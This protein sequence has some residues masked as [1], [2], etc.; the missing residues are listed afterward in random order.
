M[1]ELTV[2]KL[3]DAHDAHKVKVMLSAIGNQ[4]TNVRNMMKREVSLSHARLGCANM[5]HLWILESLSPVT[6]D[7]KRPI[8]ALC[9]TIIDKESGTDLQITVHVHTR[10]AFLVSVIFDRHIYYALPDI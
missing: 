10:L 8:E 1:R 7:F 2:P 9:W 4:L 6:H 3:P 5:V